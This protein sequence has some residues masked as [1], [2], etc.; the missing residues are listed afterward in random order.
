MYT[1]QN[2]IEITTKAIDG[3]SAQLTE[4]QDRNGDLLAQIE[5][6]QK[7]YDD[8]AANWDTV[9]KACDALT[10]DAKKLE[11]EEVGYQEKRKHLVSKQKKLK[12]ST[13]DDGHAKSEALATIENCSGAIE[14]NRTKVVELEH[15]LEVEEKEL[16]E[17]RD[18]LKDK[19]DEFTTQIEAK[20]RELEPWTAKISEKQSAIDVAQSERDL[21]A[22]KATSAQTALEEAEQNIQAIKE[23]GQAKRDEYKRL[24][25]EA[26]AA[27]QELAD[28]EEKLHGM[29]AQFEALRSNLSS[30]AHKADEARASLAADKS[31]NA[32][33][34]SL[35]KLKA[36]GRIKGFHGRLGDLGVIDDK[37]DVAV[38]TACGALNNLVVDTVEQGQACIEHLRKNN[39][40]R[41]SILILE[42][43]PPRD[44]RPIQTPENVP[45][46]FD[47]IKPKDPRFAPAFYKG[48]TNTL[49]AQD[50]A[51][52]QRIGYGAK[53]WRV[54]TLA[55]QLIDPSGTMSGGGNRVARG[56]MSSK[57]KADKV[58]PEVV[59]QYEKERATLQQELN[60]FQNDRRAVEQEVA[61]LRKRIPDIE[62]EMEKIELD[63][64]TGSKR[65]AEA[66][67]RLS[68]LASQ[69][70]PDAADET[71]I[72]QLDAEIASLT[73]NAN[74][75]REKSSGINEEIKELQNK[76]LEVGGVKLRAIQ[77]KFMTTKGLLDLANDAITKAEV[78]QAK[79]QHDVE[80]LQ[81]AIAANTAKVE[82]VDAELE[83]VEGD[84]KA[85]S[86][87]L[88]T[89]RQSVE[90]AQDTSVD[91]KEQLAE[92]KAKL[93]EAS[94]EINAFRK[95]EMDL[96]QKIDDN[97]RAQKDSKDK[98]KHWAKRHEELELAYIECVL[99]WMALTVQ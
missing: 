80:K 81:K 69:N 58:A 37:Y 65:I 47:L 15:K 4:E 41:A 24:K 74:T 39:I 82:E 60:G 77:S 99:Q 16:E 57:L 2:N 36:Q 71:R 51:Q 46:L 64:Q 67:K 6:L 30:A 12:K 61:R 31:E 48:L 95:I 75:L 72:K 20:Q 5:H 90:E 55:G 21:L 10:K 22:Q 83:S 17:V 93:D 89:L 43:L 7:E 97:A 28:A 44:L 29:G 84:L 14:T 68:E 79:A 34:S 92:S 70:K 25:K 63:I 40:G 96:K 32:V 13:S 19:T 52:A 66:E 3:L 9:K 91:V 94:T 18:S 8:K 45:R 76:I 1:L 59:A 50:L 73:K 42:K 87:D 98:Y 38:T 53:R 49:V 27:K 23:G 85:I 11:K 54:V 26:A 35:N 88:A 33:L 62:M 56:G 78:G 86:D